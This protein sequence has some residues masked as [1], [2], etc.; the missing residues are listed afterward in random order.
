MTDEPTSRTLLEQ[1]KTA[2]ASL[3]DEQRPDALA[4][5]RAQGAWTARERIDYLLDADSFRE[6]G[7]LVE[8]DRSNALSKDLQAPADGVFCKSQNIQS[9]RVIV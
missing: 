1:L 4:K 6:T 2:R 5:R 3:T 9:K 7:G 8:P